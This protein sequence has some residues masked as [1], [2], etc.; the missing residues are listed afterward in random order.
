MPEKIPG[1]G[2]AWNAP[3]AR[4]AGVDPDNSHEAK[5]HAFKVST[6]SAKRGVLASYLARYTLTFTGLAL[7][8]CLIAA[9]GLVVELLAG[10]GGLWIMAGVFVVVLMAAMRAEGLS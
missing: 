1:S 7:F 4:A 10:I 5:A 6:E 8:L 3:T 9:T 2:D